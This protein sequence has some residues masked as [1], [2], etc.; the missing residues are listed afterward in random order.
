MLR[1]E[2]HRMLAS[3]LLFLTLMY[4]FPPT[5]EGAT[6]LQINYYKSMPQDEVVLVVL[7]VLKLLKRP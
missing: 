3:N 1:I 5:I 2:S 4:G 6:R 7:A